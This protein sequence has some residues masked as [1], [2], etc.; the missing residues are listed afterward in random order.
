MQ[1]QEYRCNSCQKLLF[2]GI[3]VDS[4][5]EVKC[6]GCGSLNTFRGVSQERLLCF[7]DEC[8]N[9]VKRETRIEAIEGEDD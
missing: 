7:K 9:R 5:V 8:P 2:K 3:L 6:R 1:F 4:E